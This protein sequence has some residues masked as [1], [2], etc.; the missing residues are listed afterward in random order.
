MIPSKICCAIDQKRL[1]T[2]A[3]HK[4]HLATQSAL[5]DVP[6]GLS[7]FCKLGCVLP[8]DGHEHL[9]HHDDLVARER[10]LLYRVAK[11]D[12]RQSV[13][14][15]VCGVERVDARI[16]GEF[17]V[18]DGLFFAEGPA[19]VAIRFAYYDSRVWSGFSV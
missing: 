9:G 12:L 14:V 4:T 2:E 16:V 18:L 17:Y 15:Y 13:R 8:P 6:I 10:E 7:S 3:R 5:V 1:Q 11:D 19:D